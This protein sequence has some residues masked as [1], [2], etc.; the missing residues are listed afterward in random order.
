MIKSVKVINFLGESITLKMQNPEESGFYIKQVEG[1]GPTKATI[2]LT[3]ILTI[4]GQIFNS[5]KLGSRNILLDLGFFDAHDSLSIED[6]RLLSYK[7]FPVQKPV[8]VIVSTDNREGR[9]NGYVETNEPVIFS[10]EEST[11]ISI[12]CPSAYLSDAEENLN[13]ITGV[14]SLFSFPFSNESLTE[15]LIEFS[16][17]YTESQRVINYIGDA[18]TGIFATIYINGGS[19]TNLHIQNMTSNQDMMIDTVK[20]A[21]LTGSG[22][23]DGDYVYI[24]T[25]KGAKSV[26]LF[27]AG[28]YY[29]IINA[30]GS[31]IEWITLERGNNRLG[32]VC[33]SG[34]AYVNLT[35]QYPTLYEGV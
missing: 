26:E 28:I 22:L 2:N 3:D 16:K 17:L 14:E 5:I 13:V 23:I 1:I 15:P 32:F 18:D 27:R 20:L 19:V 33:D 29:N 25:Y 34:S 24:S 8:T 9:T 30:M 10:K 6:I 12:V 7:Y 21:A 35:V 11:V 4:D 31:G